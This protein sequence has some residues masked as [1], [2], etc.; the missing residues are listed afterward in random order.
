MGE[1]SVTGNVDNELD[2]LRTFAAE[3]G[4]HLLYFIPRDNLVQHAEINRQT[5]VQYK[6]ES[7]QAA[8]YRSLAKAVDSNTLFTIPEPIAADRLEQLLLEHGMM[9]MPEYK[10]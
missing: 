1:L 8:E 4:S 7:A 5:V 6:S 3:L 10:I 2:L 9:E